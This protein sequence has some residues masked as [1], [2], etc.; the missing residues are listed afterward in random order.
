LLHLVCDLFELDVTIFLLAFGA[1]HFT[2]RIFSLFVCFLFMFWQRLC[3][4]LTLHSPAALLHCSW[5][6]FDL[7]HEQWH[8]PPSLCL[9]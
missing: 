2:H 8:C 5:I 4:L 1:K 6:V 9:P 7:Q 3:H